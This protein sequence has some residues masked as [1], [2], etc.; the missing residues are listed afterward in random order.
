MS[1]TS[2]LLQANIER[3]HV[4]IRRLGAKTLAL[5]TGVGHMAPA[6]RGESGQVSD[7]R[8]WIANLIQCRP[9]TPRYVP[10][11]GVDIFEILERVM[12]E[13]VRSSQEQQAIEAAPKQIDPADGD[14]RAAGAPGERGGG[15]GAGAGAGAVPEPVTLT[16]ATPLKC[17]DLQ[18]QFPPD[19]LTGSTKGRII[20]AV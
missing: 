11:E 20:S 10:A 12:D 14:H 9:E 1:E 16:P 13:I 8:Y 5:K 15:P 2:V 7:N 19:H 3:L 6:R 17:S 4:V 18:F